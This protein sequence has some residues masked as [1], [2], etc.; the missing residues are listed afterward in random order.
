MLH[1]KP[2]VLKCLN[3]TPQFWSPPLACVLKRLLLVFRYTTVQKVNTIFQDFG[4]FFF[5]FT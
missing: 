1:G 2:E 4:D 3:F 5:G